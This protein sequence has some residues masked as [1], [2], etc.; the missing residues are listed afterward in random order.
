MR[1]VAP[2]GAVIDKVG[3]GGGG[4]GYF[5]GTALSAPPTFPSGQFA[6]IRKYSAGAPVNTNDNA[7]DF[8]YVSTSDND[9][10]HG[11]PVLGAPGPGNL[12]SPTTR[13]DILQSGL[14]SPSVSASTSPNR[15]VSGTSPR[16]LVV[17]RTVTNCSGQ[18]QV[19]ACAHAPAGTTAQTVTRLRFRITGLTTL[20]S[21]GAG[22]GQAVLKAD[23]SADQTGLPGANSC[24]GTTTVFGLTLDAP[25]VSG[26]GGLGSTWTA[27]PKLPPGGLAPGQC[28]N[29]AFKFDITQ[30]GSFSFAYNAEAGR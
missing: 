18:P 9:V 4:P 1:L 15:I 26:S 24:N 21:P 3:F 10:A 19:G 27:T 29:V 23:S 7:A 12:V 13:N 16:T 14:V 5:A 17:N 2:D 25:S 20:N 30:G 22:A 11:S 8:S 6:W 28:I